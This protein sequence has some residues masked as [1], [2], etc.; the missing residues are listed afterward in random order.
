MDNELLQIL[1]ELKSK[2]WNKDLLNYKRSLIKNPANQPTNSSLTDFNIIKK[3]GLLGLI[4]GGLLG[5]FLNLQWVTYLFIACS[6]CISILLGSIFG[7]IGIILI[8]IFMGFFILFGMLLVPFLLQSVFLLK[9]IGVL[10][11]SFTGSILIGFSS[12]VALHLLK[13]SDKQFDKVCRTEELTPREL[14]SFWDNRLK[15]YLYSHQF[16]V[17]NKRAKAIEDSNY[18]SHR[19][20]LKTESFEKVKIFQSKLDYSKNVIKQA[21]QLLEIINQ[22]ERGFSEHINS[23]R[24]IVKKR[25]E[26]LNQILR[27]NQLDNRIDNLINQSES[28]S[29]QWLAERRMLVSKTDEAQESLLKYMADI[30]DSISKAIEHN[31]QNEV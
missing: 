8:P 21:D 20:N 10:I 24:V 28:V 2:N 14:L 4:S 19:C 31:N 13:K 29:Q 25:D 16:N 7:L 12:N 11:G 18:W 23:L 30:T 6:A 17:L 22:L 5:Y 15:N 3:F 27:K 26:E 1:E 9:V